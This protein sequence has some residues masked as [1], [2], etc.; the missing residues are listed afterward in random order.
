MPSTR[1]IREKDEQRS[2]QGVW[3]LQ[4]LHLHLL[5]FLCSSIISYDCSIASYDVE[6]LHCE[7]LSWEEQSSIALV[8]NEDGT[9][10]NFAVK[11][12]HCDQKLLKICLA[13][14]MAKEHG[15]EKTE[16]TAYDCSCMCV[17]MQVM[18]SHT[19]CVCVCLCAFVHHFLQQLFE[20][21]LKLVV[22]AMS[23]VLMHSIMRC[24]CHC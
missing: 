2:K 7:E 5:L 4:Q 10:D 22:A 13:N 12:I 11:C 8:Y 15:F 9:V 18:H 6:L 24:D 16:V 3:Y 14:H 17:V 20:Q 21:W 23:C 19:M 1:I